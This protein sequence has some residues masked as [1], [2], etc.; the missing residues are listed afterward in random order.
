MAAVTQGTEAPPD[1]TDEL[2]GA[3]VSYNAAVVRAAPSVVSV[4]ASTSPADLNAS[5]QTASDEGETG[6]NTRP[7]R[8]RTTQGSGVIIDPN[9]LIVTNA[10]ILADADTINVALRDGRLH[11]ATMVGSDQET[12]IAVLQIPQTNLP[13]LAL[14]T[15]PPL[16]VGDVVLA[17]GNPFG[18]GQTV[19]Q[20]IVSATRRRIAGASP[21]Q[22]FVQIDAAINPGNSGGALINPAGQLVGVNTAVF[23]RFGNYIGASDVAF[24]Q[25][26]AAQGIGFT[27]PASLLAE[28]VPKIV[29]HGR[30][31]RG[32]LGADAEDLPLFPALAASLGTAAGA[33]IIRTAAG[34]PAEMIGLRPRDVIVA[35]DDMA[36][37]NANGLLLAVAAYMPGKPVQLDLI[38]DGQALGVDVVLGERPLGDVAGVVRE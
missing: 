11:P 34:G 29:E 22:N 32:W 7:Q 8:V 9:G 10:H 21:W 5:D 2:R 13:A 37:V 25:D 20:G 30:V 16:A 38:R 14:D 23:R 36:I 28:V 4:Y 27:I 35:V 33:V 19:T 24:D 31:A 18:V 26:A 12:D 6:Q 17:I 15:A 3:V 1:S